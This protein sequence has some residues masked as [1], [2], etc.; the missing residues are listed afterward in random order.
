M[1]AESELALL[2]HT[3][4]LT[5]LHN[6]RTLSDT[7]DKE[8]RR[9]KRTGTVF[10]LL[11]VDL[12]RFNAYNDTYGHQAGDD[13]LAAVARCIGNHIRRPADSA[14]DE[15]LYYAKATGRNKFALSGA[16]AA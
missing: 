5:G 14:A 8:W 11:F 16:M 3:D 2:A 13:V 12:D 15:A 10:S 6:R 7:L 4:S 1:R 9:A